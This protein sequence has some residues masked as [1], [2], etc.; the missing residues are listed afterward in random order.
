[1]KQIFHQTKIKEKCTSKWKSL[2]VSSSPHRETNRCCSRALKIPRFLPRRWLECRRY[3]RYELR[4]EESW[5]PGQLKKNKLEVLGTCTG[6]QIYMQNMGVSKNTGTPK[7]SNLNR[8]FPYFHH[9]FWGTS[10]FSYWSKI[11]FP[12]RPTDMFFIPHLSCPNTARHCSR[13]ADHCGGGTGQCQIE[14]PYLATFFQVERWNDCCWLVGRNLASKL[15]SVEVG[16][17]WNPIIYH[18][19]FFNIPGGTGSQPWTV[20]LL[21]WCLRLF[22]FGDAI[23]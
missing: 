20:G 6:H 2:E 16:S 21:G 17:C 22:C 18:V 10:I 7:S 14:R 11:K 5:G 3:N 9:P 23:M 15:T 12:F 19:F 13:H 8:L 1:M 4:N